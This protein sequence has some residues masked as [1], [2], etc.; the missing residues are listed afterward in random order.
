MDGVSTNIMKYLDPLRAL[1]AAMF[2]S[3]CALLGACGGGGG[4][5]HM[6]VGDKIISGT[7]TLAGTTDGVPGITVTATGQN[8]VLTDQNGHYEF[9]QVLDNATYT[10]MASQSGFVFNPGSV[11][12]TVSGSNVGGVN[13]EITSNPYSTTAP[14]IDLDSAF[15]LGQLFSPS[16][17]FNE[18]LAFIRQ[19][20]GLPV[21]TKLLWPKSTRIAV[22]GPAGLPSRI[23]LTRP[24]DIPLWLMS[25]DVQS[26]VLQPGQE[27]VFDLDYRRDGAYNDLPGPVHNPYLISMEVQDPVFGWL[28]AG[29]DGF[30][31]L[32]YEVEAGYAAGSVL[33]ADGAQDWGGIDVSTLLEIPSGGAFGDVGLMFYNE[34]GLETGLASGANPPGWVCID[35]NETARFVGPE[36]YLQGGQ[37]TSEG[38]FVVVITSDG[39][40]S[41][42]RPYYFADGTQDE[43]V[44]TP[45]MLFDFVHF[46]SSDI[47]I[48]PF[49]SGS[50]GVHFGGTAVFGDPFNLNLNGEPTQFYSTGVGSMD[51]AVSFQPAPSDPIVG[52]VQLDLSTNSGMIKSPW[53]LFEILKPLPF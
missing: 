40:C 23:T 31:L 53:V 41:R 14:E 10:V 9:M 49:V 26:P 52:A 13:F 17:N 43:I 11:P 37:V 18:A 48:I 47:G 5:H 25:D 3:L 19:L 15:P 24:M 30:F 7:V 16:L 6:P 12:V 28:P 44:T 46:A 1:R 34:L 33:L 50:P 29:S 4:S 35:P 36:Y 8:P 51:P 38:G 32:E 39:S 2:V 20:R 42:P 21:G 27:H 22:G 45:P